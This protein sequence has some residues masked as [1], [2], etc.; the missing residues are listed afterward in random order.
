MDP[1]QS[2]PPP[3]QQ[4]PTPADVARSL[5][6]TRQTRDAAG[7]LN[8]SEINSRGN[9]TREMRVLSHDA[10]ARTVEL[11]FSSE[12]PVRQW[13]GLEILD[14]DPGSVVL[15]RLRNGAALLMN[16]D[17]DDQVGV[18]DSVTIDADR[19]GRATVRFSRGDRAQEIFQD[20][21]DGI[22]K[23]VSVGYRVLEAKPDGVQDGIDVIRITKWEPY[24]ISLVS[25]P[26]DPSV[27][28]G[29]SAEIHQEETPKPNG[30][31]AS[32]SV[33]TNTRGATSPNYQESHMEKILRDAKGNLVRAE[34]DADGNITKI[35]EVLERAGD[36][37][38]SGIQQGAD[39]ERNRV[40]GISDLG[41][42]YNSRELALQFI[43]D[44]KSPEEFQR[45]LLDE[46]DKRGTAPLADKPDV[47]IGLDDTEVRRYSFMNAVRA[48]ANPNDAGAQK[49]AA[50][51]LECS[52][53]VEKQMG[54]SARGF[55]V[56]QDVLGRAF[57]AGGAANSPT[58]ST[59]GADLVA[60]NLL[61]GS[62]IEMLRNRTTIMRLGSVMG[63]LVGNVDVPKQTGGATAYWLAEGADATE[64]V[65]TIG[66]ISLSPKTVAAY[67]DITRRLTM[68]STPDAE[69]IVRRDLLNALGQAIDKAG[70]YGSGA[71]NQPKGIKNYTGINAVDFAVA[72]K[73]TFAE[74]VDMES[75]IAADNADVA[76]MAY[77][78]NAAFRGY[79]KSTVKF[80]SAG[81]ATI[82][83]PGNTVNGYRSEITNQIADGD[84]FFG[85]FADLIV[86]LW[87]GLD[88]MVD[89]YSLSKSGGI[90]IVVFQDVDFAVRR[91][92]S[93][94]YG[95]LVP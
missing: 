45:A 24:E 26:A 22:R 31:N 86:A 39:G 81:S 37:V 71:S 94:C 58:G 33:K 11:A 51:E 82:W 28:V 92:E 16:H 84:V 64:G 76:Q 87:G 93:F 57:N 43:T 34:V 65:P 25:V 5:K 68:Q 91:V 55:L 2:N 66:Q 15:D 9:L 7:T 36:D 95:V 48:L 62:F 49:A 44:G 74:L 79:A 40:R 46:M 69:G 14:H 59:T 27:G 70:Y 47:E 19:K 67:S 41:E 8:V 75:Q 85:N 32:K 56:P 54:K 52:R 1:K 4:R 38:R 13:F 20:V 10:E 29:R 21:I 63:G 77:V 6:G 23:L 80:S 53:A 30:Q 35:L 18:I 61:S 50:F 78:A 73:P 89:P 83:E 42:K 3:I 60:T 88:L 90:R 12:A 72:G 17:W